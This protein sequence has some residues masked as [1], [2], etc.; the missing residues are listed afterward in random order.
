MVIGVRDSGIGILS[1][2]WKK[3]FE[4]FHQEKEPCPNLQK[5][6]GWVGDR[7]GSWR[8]ITEKSGRR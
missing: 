4:K 6:Q 7:K 2:N 3:I 5:E 8:P 1:R